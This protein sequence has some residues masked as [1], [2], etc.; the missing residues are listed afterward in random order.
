MYNTASFWNHLAV[1]VL[2]SPKNCRNLKKRT[3][4]LLFLH[5]E[6]NWVRISYFQSDLRFYDCLITHWLETRTILVVIERIYR[7]KFKSNYLK[8]YKPFPLLCL[9]FWN[10]HEISNF[11]KKNMRLTSQVFLK[12][13]TLK[14]L[15]ISM[16]HRATLWKHFGSDRDNLSRKLLKSEKE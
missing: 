10:L 14:D 6:R 1:I 5:S 13:L 11:L 15:L 8:N 12:L 7:Y 16:H 3:F 2:T 9:N 4:I